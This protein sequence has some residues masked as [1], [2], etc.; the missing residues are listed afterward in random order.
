M[1]I[2]LCD[3]A[4]PVKQEGS[5]VGYGRST[6]GLNDADGGRQFAALGLAGN[7]IEVAVLIP[8]RSRAIRI[9]ATVGALEI[10]VAEDSGIQQLGAGGIKTPYESVLGCA[11][12]LVSG[13]YRAAGSWKAGLVVWGTILVFVAGNVSAAGAIHAMAVAY[14]LP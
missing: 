13:D 4:A 7:Q 9:A 12:D 5:C 6:A 1:G 8:P 10:Q 2:E 3:E 11:P 14:A